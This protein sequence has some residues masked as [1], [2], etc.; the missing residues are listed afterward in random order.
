MFYRKS[1]A[2]LLVFS[3]VLLCA[4][5]NYTGTDATTEDTGSSE[6][7]SGEFNTKIKNEKNIK[8]KNLKYLSI[9]RTINIIKK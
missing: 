1:M 7:T 2:L 9:G 5:G 4:C 3:L 6:Q 8:K